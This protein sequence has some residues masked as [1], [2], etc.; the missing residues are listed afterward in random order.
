MSRLKGWFNHF[1][2]LEIPRATVI[3]SEVRRGGES[4][5]LHFREIHAINDPTWQR[6]L[7]STYD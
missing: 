3:L 7:L 1:P 5:D 4:K 2:N 6:Q